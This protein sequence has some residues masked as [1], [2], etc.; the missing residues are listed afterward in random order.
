MDGNAIS[1]ASLENVIDLEN[2]GLQTLETNEVLTELFNNDNVEGNRCDSIPTNTNNIKLLKLAEVYPNPTTGE[3]QI[4]NLTEPVQYRLYDSTGRQYES[5]IY[6][7]GTITVKHPGINLIR[8]SA[9]GE[10]Y[11]FKVVRIGGE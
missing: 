6:F 9:K 5:G 4:K 2:G 7:N 11:T 3:V 8:L 10:S 1:T